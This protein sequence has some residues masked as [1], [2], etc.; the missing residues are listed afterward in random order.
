MI[1]QVT[2]PDGRK[3][4]ACA[5]L[6]TKIGTGDSATD[7]FWNVCIAGDGKLSFVSSP[8]YAMEFHDYRGFGKKQVA[9][10]LVDDPEPG[11][12]LVGEVTVL[13]D[14][15]KVK[16]S[17]R[18]FTPLTTDDSRFTSMSVDSAQMDRLIAGNPAV[19]WPTVRSGN[20]SGRLAMYISADANGNVREAWPLNSDNAGLEDPA[21]DQVRKWKLRPAVDAAGNAIQVDGGLGFAFESHIDDPIP[22]ITGADIGKVMS[23]CP[24]NP[25]LQKGLMPSGSSFTIRVSVN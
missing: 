7:A 23:G 11:T 25:V 8:R 12:Q 5:K 3:S 24:Y 15:S 6:K 14:E 1:D 20:T 13:E 22:I 16:D 2:L 21:R 17:D 10:R 4:D 18:L 9:R 19:E